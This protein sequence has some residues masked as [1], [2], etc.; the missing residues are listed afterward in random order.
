M[1][2]TRGKLREMSAKLDYIALLV[3]YLV[4]RMPDI[5]VVDH[6][7]TL[8]FPL[9]LFYYSKLLFS[10][11]GVNPAITDSV[12]APAN[13][14]LIYPPGIY[15][16][17]TM[18]GSVRNAFYLLLAIQS[19]V[20]LLSYRL[21]KPVVPRMFA[22]VVAIFVAYY[23]TS[24]R[25]WYP[26]YIVQ[27]LMAGVVVLMI[28][29]A[30]V[31]RPWHL[32]VCGLAS[33]LIIILKHN[34]GICF[35][36]LIVTMIF[37]QSCDL[38]PNKK[39]R[40]VGYL[41][42]FG[43]LGSGLVFGFR[44]PYWDEVAFYLLPYF[45]FWLFVLK[46]YLRGELSLDA[47][48]FI[49][50]GAVYLAAALVFPVTVFL[51][52]G[53]TIGYQRYWYSLFG[54]GFD[55]IKF[56]DFGIWGIFQSY[57]NSGGRWSVNKGFILISLVGPFFL[58]MAGIWTLYRSKEYDDPKKLE[59]LLVVAVGVM[60]AFM[61]FPLEDHKI[62]V[63]KMFIFL[64]VFAFLLTNISPVAWKIASCTALILALPI[65]TATAR[66]VL[67]VATVDTAAGTPEMQRIIDMP[68]QQEIAEELGKQIGVLKRSIHNKPYLV[69]ASEMSPL[70]TLPILVDNVD[71]QY[72][73]RLDAPALNETVV[74]RV[75]SMLEKAPFVIVNAKDYR[76]PILEDDDFR[77]LMEY[78][79]ARFSAID[80]YIE[81]V[82]ASSAVKH[83][84]GFVVL[85]AK[86]YIE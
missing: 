66:N 44:L 41:F 54:M 70:M 47:R 59:R 38:H 86:K 56:W 9:D 2:E 43:V 50:K 6:F 58:N 32:L 85:K 29:K 22:F 37:F 77:R 75:E 34:E 74:E 49:T 84:D 60:A 64:Y 19:V 81:P 36:A 67:S 42:L 20:P 71:P 62:A 55:H 76:A 31:I 68:L 65:A 13:A 3:I 46:L 11:F 7:V 23:G 80:E 73:V 40:F 69:L 57:F 1:S 10:G 4:I 21:L 78:T 52:F 51:W 63:S 35:A 5:L 79:R 24:A 45:A 61:L 28:A 30:K 12:V 18:F 82:N 53:S 26:D 27:P 8:I 15:L 39:D 16:L 83:I 17:S 48:E 33:G 14:S 25:I 72:Y